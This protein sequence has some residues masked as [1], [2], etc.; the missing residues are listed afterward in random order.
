MI[1]Y[2]PTLE[3]ISVEALSFM[4]MALHIEMFIIAHLEKEPWAQS[5]LELRALHNH[6]HALFSFKTIMFVCEWKH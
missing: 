4:D 1:T 6:C 5:C 2:P 3:L